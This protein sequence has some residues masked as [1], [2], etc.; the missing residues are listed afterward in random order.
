M[1]TLSIFIAALLSNFSAQAAPAPGQAT[2]ALVK[3]ELGLYRSA[4]GFELHNGGTGWFQTEAPAENKFVSIIYNS[5]KN[6]ANK[7][8]A[9]SLTVRTDKLDK[10]V[11]IDK[12]VSRWLKEYP[13]YGFDVLGSKGF[14]QNKAKGYVVDLLNRD[15]KKQLRQVVFLKKQTAVILTCRENAK[16]FDAARKDC[17]QIIRTFKWIE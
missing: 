13:K 4:L 17:N 6:A 10:E 15:T 12:Y 14:V 7:D 3:P 2:S 16:N 5:P 8:S 9:S 11:A 1:K